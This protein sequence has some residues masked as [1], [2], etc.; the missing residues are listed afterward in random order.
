M[1]GSHI[2]KKASL[3]SLEALNRHLSQAQ[4]LIGLYGKSANSEI[5]SK[6]ELEQVQREMKIMKNE[7][8]SE[9]MRSKD[10]LKKMQ[11]QEGGA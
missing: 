3:S 11:L 9:L 1:D 8:L 5:G 2:R 6:A 4:A 10:M 7:L